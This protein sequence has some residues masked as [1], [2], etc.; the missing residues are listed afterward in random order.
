MNSYSTLDREGR[1]QRV[2]EFHKDSPEIIR[3]IELY[4]VCPI[5]SV[6]NYYTHDWEFKE[7][8]CGGY[9]LVGCKRCGM[10]FIELMEHYT[11]SSSLCSCSDAVILHII[12]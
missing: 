9:Q 5:M 1:Y 11:T 3:L 7:V 10:S 4:G 6:D 8:K 12:K 2:L